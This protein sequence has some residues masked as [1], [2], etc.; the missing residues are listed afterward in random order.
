MI[1]S[2]YEGKRNVA[3]A[4]IIPFDFVVEKEKH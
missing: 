1:S 4:Q 2:A 3:A